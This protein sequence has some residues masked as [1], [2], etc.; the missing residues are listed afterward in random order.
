MT[1]CK[2]LFRVHLRTRADGSV[3]LVLGQSYYRKWSLEAGAEIQRQQ[4]AMHDA[5]RVGDAD[6]HYTAR[7][8]QDV[9]ISLQSALNSHWSPEAAELAQ[10]RR[11]EYR[12]LT[13]GE[14]D[15]LNQQRVQTLGGKARSAGPHGAPAEAESKFAIFES[16][17]L[18]V[19][20]TRKVS[21][22][23]GKIG[24]QSA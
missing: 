14:Y 5:D 8:L 3:Q 15:A 19:H 10:H 4:Q 21:P 2:S 24:P 6:A 16:A 12:P 17:E 7:C 13:L 9:T 20:V 1:D 23:N 11:E 22:E 18:Y